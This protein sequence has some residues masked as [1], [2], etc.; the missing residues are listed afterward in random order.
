MRYSK[1]EIQRLKKRWGEPLL[2]PGSFTRDEKTGKITLKPEY[3]DNPEV[4]KQR[5]EGE[6]HHWTGYNLIEIKPIETFQ[7]LLTTRLFE[8]Q[9]VLKSEINK[10]HK[11]CILENTR[12]KYQD[13]WK[14]LA[15][16]KFLEMLKELRKYG[17]DEYL[18]V[19]DIEKKLRR[20]I[21][22]DFRGAILR[23]AYFKGAD[24]KFA[25]FDWADYKEAHF[26][27]AD[28]KEAHFDGANCCGAFFG[29]IEQMDDNK[30]IKKEP[31]NLSDVS[32]N[33]KSKFIGVDTS[34]VDWSKNP[35]MKRYIEQ[36]QFVHAIKQKTPKGLTW[37]ISLLDY[38]SSLWNWIGWAFITIMAFAM[39][40]AGLDHLYDA[41]TI[42][43]Y[44]V[45]KY[46]YFSVITFSTLGFGDITATNALSMILVIAE[47]CLGYVFLGGL[48]TFLAN[49]LGRR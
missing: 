38:L 15:E 8:N 14:S 45:W 46:I 43:E 3:K 27:G 19:T 40:Y 31:C 21:S 4:A 6:G 29:A 49:W 36:Q 16:D 10:G 12:D 33:N 41:K 44:S 20:E 35:L 47:V 11:T 25:H 26:D 28:C 22:I 23:F 34:C 18:Q 13:I 2:K 48:I 7:V 32:W 9:D 30:I 1:E 24:F 17:L 37:V 5:L 39:F 42:I